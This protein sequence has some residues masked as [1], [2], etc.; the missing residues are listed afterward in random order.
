MA[1]ID[2]FLKMMVMH[3]AERLMLAPEE[4]PYVLTGGETTE[5]AM[6]AV[7]AA[8][9]ERLAGEVVADD[10]PTGEPVKGTYRN[11]DGEEFIYLVSPGAPGYHIEMSP[12]VTD[13]SPA[14]EPP[15]P[16]PESGSSPT[17]VADTP[18]PVVLHVIA[19][20]VSA[21][22]SDIF[23]STG[24]P[25]RMRLHGTIHP[26]DSAPITTDQVLNL[27]P[28]SFNQQELES[29]GSTDFGATWELSGRSRRLRVNVFRHTSGLAAAIRPIRDH[30]PSLDELGL[31]AKLLELGEYPSGLVLVTGASGSGKSTT[32][33]AL[34]EHINRTKARHII[35]I[36]DPIEFAHHEHQS[37]IHQREVGADVESFSSGLRA[38][39]RE[40][41]DVILLGEMRDL[42]TISAAL[43]AAE[44]GHL[45]LSTLHTGSATAAINRIIDVYPGHQQTHVRNQL[46]TS[47]K[48]VVAQRLIRAADRSGRTP[49]IEKLLVN[50]AIA[51]SIREGHEHHMKSTMQTGAE[52]GMVT[53]ERS[54]ASLV[55]RGTI[56]RDDAYRH[57]ND[58]QALEKLLE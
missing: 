53:L 4:I 29:S 18:D 56:T 30:I 14:P 20:G 12:A 58:P 41:P 13:D 11:D 54:L 38:A 50:A 49:A 33:A 24:K 17:A 44:T 43:T 5:L 15:A 8:L 40:N 10:L 2:T 47:L 42:P 16:V 23:L 9:S 19:Q 55:C 36:E 26:L 57:A 31:P 52:A 28:G 46:A 21:G 27:L 32:L 39:L 6:P 48:A 35:T 45:V 34:V 3:R 1:V 22:A 25:A 7:P 51:N 37:L